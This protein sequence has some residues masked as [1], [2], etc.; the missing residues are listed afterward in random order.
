MSNKR[1]FNFHYLE[2]DEKTKKYNFSCNKDERISAPINQ[3][4]KLIGCISKDF[5]FYFNGS[6]LNQEDKMH[7]ED[8]FAG[9]GAVN[10]VAFPLRKMIEYNKNEKKPVPNISDQYKQISEPVKKDGDKNTTNIVEEKKDEKPT[11]KIEEKKE[12]EEKKYYNDII[13]PFCKTSSI[14]ENDGMKLK[15]INCEN[16]HH[17]E[18]IRYDKFDEYEYNLDDLSP[19]NLNKLSKTPFIKCSIC[20]QDLVLMTPPRQLYLCTCHSIMCPECKKTHEYPG[21]YKVEVENRNYRCLIHDK[22]F[23][24]Y[25]L[26]CNMN[27]CDSCLS[28]HPEASHEVL[29]FHNLNPKESYIKEIENEIESQKTIL[30]NFYENSKKILENVY[31]YLNKY[32]LIERTFL[33]R[34][35]SNVRNFQLLQ[36]IRNRSIFFDNAIFQD[37]KRFKDHQKDED[38]LNDLIKI[39]ENMKKVYINKEE[40]TQPQQ[41]NNSTN[42]LTIKYKIENPNNLNRNVKI[43]DP[44]FV[45]KNKNK[46]EIEISYTDESTQQKKISDDKKLRE[47]FEN[48]SNSEKLE[49]V[50]REKYVG[51]D[52]TENQ[53]ITDMGYM[54]NNC[55]NFTSIDFSQWSVSNITNIESMFQLTEINDIPDGLSKLVTNKLTSMRGLFCKCHNLEKINPDRIK[56]S[57]NT[58]NVKDMSLLFN[59]CIKLNKV[60]QKNIKDWD[61]K[62]VEDMSYMF[63]RCTK[64]KEIHGIGS[65]KT[66]SLKNA[67][68]MFNKCE[69]LTNLS[70]IGSWTMDNVTDISIIFQFCENLEKFPDIY[71]WNLSKVKDISGVFSG[72]TK[73]KS[74]QIKNLNRW[75]LKS[76][77][78]MCGLFNECTGLTTFPDVIN[79][80]TNNVTD[81]SG[82]FC[83]C[84][85]MTDLPPNIN[86][87]DISKVTDMS[88]IFD[89]CSELKNISLINNWKI[90]NVKN[91][92]DSLR[93]TNLS[94]DV[95]NKWKE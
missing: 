34:Y 47:Y 3:F 55:K 62:N 1:E 30:N 59:G 15:I 46:C 83:G 74:P 70:G 33:N 88:Y 40:K 95:K 13:C 94:E 54:L 67:C 22:N 82:L 7:I 38:K 84:S 24:S 78:S 86:K 12:V 32:I 18:D 42:Q 8:K 28:L 77:T 27:I 23:T 65:W 10:I 69:E 25:C 91:K 64:L 66:L 90:K 71:K 76:I 21:H 81:M 44:V 72:C 35:R 16:F 41:N 50:L 63:S 36:N 56:F 5:A 37:L 80:C 87:W 60:E 75:Q 58:Q 4:L 73:L 92:T 85:S 89:G 19:E 93:G 79:W 31:N 6:L 39:L 43:F 49:I 2:N 51:N 26:D 14:I 29:K 20:S 9:S 53:F 17:L 11:I 45:E 52:N 48:K 57:N 61:V 68:G